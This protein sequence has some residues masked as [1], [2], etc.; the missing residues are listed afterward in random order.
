MTES[1]PDFSQLHWTFGFPGHEGIVDCFHLA[2]TPLLVTPKPP[3]WAEQNFNVGSN[4]SDASEVVGYFWKPKIWAK[5]ERFEQ[6]IEPSWCMLPCHFR[7]VGFFPLLC[8]MVTI[9]KTDIQ[10]LK[11]KHESL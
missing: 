3:P 8:S 7:I 4:N 2:A 6:T 9:R 5:I 10:V 11:K 1:P